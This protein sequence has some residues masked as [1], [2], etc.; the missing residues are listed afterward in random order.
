MGQCYKG[1]LYLSRAELW[2]ASDKVKSADLKLTWNEESIVKEPTP[3]GLLWWKVP[4]SLFTTVYMVA[5]P[6]FM[7]PVFPQARNRFGMCQAGMSQFEPINLEIKNVNPTSIITSK[8]MPELLEYFRTTPC[9][10]TEVQLWCDPVRATFAVV[11]FK[12]HHWSKIYFLHDTLFKM[13][14][15]LNYC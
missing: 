4:A 7:T 12:K 3:P 11:V 2:A 15:Q 14:S 5:V 8:S 9:C 13:D 10:L 6:G 1:S